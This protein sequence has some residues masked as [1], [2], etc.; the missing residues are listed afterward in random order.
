MKPLAAPLVLVLALAIAN[1]PHS[2]HCALEV[3]FYK[4]KCGDTDVEATIRDMVHTRFVEDISSVAALLRLQFHDCYVR[5]HCSFLLSLLPCY[6]S[7]IPSIWSK[8]LM[9]SNFFFFFNSNVSYVLCS[10]LGNYGI[11]KNLVLMQKE[12][13]RKSNDLSKHARMCFENLR[14]ANVMGG[15]RPI[16]AL[17]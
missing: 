9:S 14:A 13:F 16:A 17:V 2:C 8:R 1:F 15:R 3:G 5:V 4:G 12:I 6:C 10:V 11:C 7:I